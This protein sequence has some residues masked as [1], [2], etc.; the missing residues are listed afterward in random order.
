MNGIDIFR[1]GWAATWTRWAGL[2]GEMRRGG[3]D[4]ASLLLLAISPSSYRAPYRSEMA[5]QIYLG[6]APVLLWFTLLVSL[7]SLVLIRIVVVTAASYGLSQYALEMVVRVLV[8]ELIPLSAA[9]FVGLRLSLPGFSGVASLRARGE[10]EKLRQRGLDPLRTLVVPRVVGCLFA[11]PALAVVSGVTAL[12]LAYLIVHGPTPWAFDSYTRRVGHVFSPVVSVV[13]A[14]K[15]VGLSLVVALVPFVSALRPRD[16]GP[17][18]SRAALNPQLRNLVV[19][20]V[21]ILLVEL[22]SLVGNYY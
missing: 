22:L 20:F 21:L 8:L 15:T 19:M 12:V 1:G 16:A 2:G 11:V 7:V 6:T 17:R 3:R 10:F 13:F 4:A 18:R 14:L 5:R 9:L